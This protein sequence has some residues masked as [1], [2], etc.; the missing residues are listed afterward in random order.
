MQKTHR[1]KEDLWKI[2]KRPSHLGNTDTTDCY[3][4]V[5]KSK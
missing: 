3:H 4:T 5:A 2:K 1:Y